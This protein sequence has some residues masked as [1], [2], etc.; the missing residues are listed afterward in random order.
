MDRFLDNKIFESDDK[1]FDILYGWGEIYS[2]NYIEEIITVKFNNGLIDYTL[3]GKRNEDDLKPSL[4]LTEYAYYGF[5]QEKTPSYK[6]YI[7]KWGKFYDNNP[8]YFRVGKLVFYVKGAEK[9]FQGISHSFK[10]FEP[11]TEEQI[12]I[13]ELE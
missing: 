8:E 10:Y 12:K 1:V 4:S 3:D 7:G 6:E 11:L 9:P 2:I 13:L 5:S